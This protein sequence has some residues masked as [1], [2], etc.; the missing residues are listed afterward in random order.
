MTSGDDRYADE[1]AD[2]SRGTTKRWRWRGRGEGGG[3]DDK[4]KDDRAG[5]SAESR[6][7][8][9]RP[10]SGHPVMFLAI[11]QIL[12]RDAA[13]QWIRYTKYNNNQTSQ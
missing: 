11:L 6:G 10:Q 9:L 5:D 3:D 2:A 13:H 4:E 12:R 1:V 8:T 7:V